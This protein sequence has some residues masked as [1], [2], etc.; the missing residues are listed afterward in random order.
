MANSRI[1]ELET[2][3]Q[4]QPFC[5]AQSVN[6]VGVERGSSRGLGLEGFSVKPSS[7]A[8]PMDLTLRPPQSSFWE[9]P[10][11]KVEKKVCLAL[12]DRSLFLR[13]KKEK[14]QLIEH[15]D[16]IHSR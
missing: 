7:E 13:E 9:W 2:R 11:S 4:H 16:V 6:Q 14:T 10:L 12:A 3:L 5:H 8:M 1:A 15:I